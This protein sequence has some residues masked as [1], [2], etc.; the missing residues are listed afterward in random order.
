MRGSVPCGRRPSAEP[1]G[2]RPVAGS[3]RAAEV[4]ERAGG[5]SRA[6]YHRSPC[7][8]IATFVI[9]T[10]AAVLAAV[11]FGML[12]PLARFGAEDGIEG[13]AFVAWRAALGVLFVGTLLVVRRGV[14]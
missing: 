4:R 8:A 12:G 10:L 9:G 7:P 2:A 5:R 13:V 11:L 14:G 1:R 3:C 6:R